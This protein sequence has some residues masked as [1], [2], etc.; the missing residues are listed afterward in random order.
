ML[1]KYEQKYQEAISGKHKEKKSFST[2]KD[3]EYI[4]NQEKLK[5]LG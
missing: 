1:I 4:G 5:A 3:P 2:F